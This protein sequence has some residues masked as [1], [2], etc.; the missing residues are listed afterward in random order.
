MSDLSHTLIEFWNQ[1]FKEIEPIKLNKDEV[2][3]ESKLD[4]E[5]KFIGDHTTRVLDIGCGLGTCLMTAKLLGQK[6]IEGIGIDPSEHAI[7]FA[8]ETVKR[9]FISGLTFFQGDHHLLESYPDHA[10]D[11]I[12]CSNTLDVIPTDISEII[13]KEIYR[14]LAPGGYFLLKLNFHLD[15]AMIEKL[16]MESIGHDMYQINGV[17]RAVNRSTEV[18][19]QQFNGLTLMRQ[20]GYKRAP[21]L[22]DD[23]ILVFTKPLL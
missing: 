1:Y 16:K 10:F 18:W 3:I 8:N 6:M 5:L 21:Q 2:K 11:G 17:L 23:R 14:L 15:Q 9:S 4:E 22:P 13:I 20:A 19:I 12:V 7:N